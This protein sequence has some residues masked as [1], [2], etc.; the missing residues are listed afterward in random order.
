MKKEFLFLLCASLGLSLALSSV[1]LAQTDKQEKHKATTVEP[2]SIKNTIH[3]GLLADG[4]EV[5]KKI[6]SLRRLKE[7]EVIKE[8][9]QH[10]DLEAPSE[11][12]YGENS[13]SEFVNPFAGL[14]VDI[15][16]QYDINLDGFV[17]P[18]EHKRISSHYGYR[19]RFGRMHYGI[20]LS[21][22]VGDTVRAAFSGKVRIAS[23][24]RRGYGHYIVIRHPNGLETVY[25]HLHRRIAQE[26]DVIKAGEPIGLGGNTGRSTGP[27][28]HFEARFMGIPLNPNDLFDFDLGVP[29]LDTYA[30]H[31]NEHKQGAKSY[32]K[33][34]SSLAQRNKSK[35]GQATNTLQ[36]SSEIK[37][38]KVRKGDTLSAI[39]KAHG[40]TVSILKQLNG[41]KSDRLQINDTLR[42]S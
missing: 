23:F 17:L 28:L 8:H 33:I 18:V 7:M 2:S 35:T 10:E 31:R 19:R 34:K 37:V 25:G 27:H 36:T 13:W 20:D 1:G 15:P 3:K 39:A 16:E 5:K 9:E 42:V 38:Y 12:L 40:I 4:I 32:T 22:S 14:S 41:L 29:R 30:F 11:A 6:S 24:E 26:G 21:L